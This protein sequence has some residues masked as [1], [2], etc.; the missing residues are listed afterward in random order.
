M[1]SMPIS[2]FLLSDSQNICDQL[3]ATLSGGEVNREAVRVEI[4]A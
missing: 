4:A 2:I 3:D 1:T